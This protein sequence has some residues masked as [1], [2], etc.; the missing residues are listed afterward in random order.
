MIESHSAIFVGVDLAWGE[1][2]PDGL[3]C[4]VWDGQSLHVNDCFLSWGNDVLLENI[5]RLTQGFSSGVISVDAP[6]IIKNKKGM[7][8]V[9]RLTHVL[10]R[11]QHAGC[12]PAYLDKITRPVVLAEKLED[13]G[14]LLTPEVR[15]DRVTL[16]EVYPHISTLHVFGIG[17]ILKYKKGKVC[18]RR[19]EFGRYQ[20]LLLHS[21]E[22]FFYG[23]SPDIDLQRFLSIKPWSKNLE[24]QTDAMLCALTGWHHWITEGKGTE[25][26]GDIETGFIVS[27][28]S[29]LNSTG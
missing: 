22:N 10:Y 25:V 29:R 21:L 1:R 5:Q 14:F 11:K 17:R 3:F 4:F 18:E 26:L 27:C 20:R 28:K 16:I 13:C 24:D 2:N 23:V 19:R 12:H 9:D 8:P 15:R 6:L 7:R